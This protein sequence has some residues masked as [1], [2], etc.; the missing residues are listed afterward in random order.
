MGMPEYF[1]LPLIPLDRVLFPPMEMALRVFEEPYKHLIGRCFEKEEELGVILFDDEGMR[2]VGCS[3]A[4]VDVDLD[5][6]SEGE[7]MDIW[8]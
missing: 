7:E 5:Q 4:V 6:E 3:A 8:F 2:E 1:H